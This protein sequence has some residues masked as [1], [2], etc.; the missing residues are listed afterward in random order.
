MYYI[1]VPSFHSVLKGNKIFQE[2]GC[3]WKSFIT[4]YEFFWA[5]ISLSK[6]SV[7]PLCVTD[8]QHTLAYLMCSCSHDVLQKAQGKLL[9]A[10]NLY[11]EIVNNTNISFIKLSFSSQV[12]CHSNTESNNAIKLPNSLF[13]PLVVVFSYPLA[14]KK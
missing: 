8:N 3:R 1:I 12:F 10:M 9:M 6:L 14:E 7:S 11:L 2:S 4:W 5:V 13:T